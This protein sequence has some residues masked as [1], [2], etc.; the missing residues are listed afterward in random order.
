MVG[1]VALTGCD[2]GEVTQYQIPKETPPAASQ[3]PGGDPHA[4]MAM[5]QPSLNWGT[6]PAGW[7]EGAQ[8]SGMRLATFNIAGENGESAEMAIIP[9]PGFAGKD[10]QLVNMW[11]MQ[12]GLPELDEAEAELKGKP[13]VIDA[14][15]GQLYEMAGTAQEV[16]SRILVASVNKDGVN[17]FF[18]LIGNDSLVSGQRSAYLEF[19][20]TVEFGAPAPVSAP[21]MAP[22]AGASPGETRWQAPEGWQQLPATQFLLDR[23]QVPGDGE[24]NAQVTVSMLGGA[25]GGL[26]PNV[27]RWRG[28]LNLAP[29]DEAGMN[30]LLSEVPAGSLKATLVTLEGTDL[31]TSAPG[32]ML[33]VV[34]SLPAE[35][36][37][38]KMTG[39]V[40]VVDAKTAEFLAF[41]NATRF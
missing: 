15:E 32:K 24:A 40:A 18:K 10:S 14:V 22:V 29:V 16:P 11:R 6:L 19:L 25:A 34:V 7:T 26:L 28:Q 30:A 4:G 23:Y 2:R 17:Y 37:F 33:T 9:M 35:T 27:N 41:V 38:F 39:P 8:S 3:A 36:W 5:S 13:L 1:L 21:A 20:K 31:Q 12:L